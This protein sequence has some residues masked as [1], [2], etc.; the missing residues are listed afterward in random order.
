MGNVDFEKAKQSTKKALDDMN[1]AEVNY[2][3]EK[4]LPAYSLTLDEQA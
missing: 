2:F 1:I 3:I 4:F